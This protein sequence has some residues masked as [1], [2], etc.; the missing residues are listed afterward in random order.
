MTQPFKFL[1]LCFVLVSISRC[2]FCVAR[3]MPLLFS[4]FLYCQLSYVSWVLP[5]CLLLLACTLWLREKANVNP[6]TNRWKAS[7]VTFLVIHNSSCIMTIIIFILA[8][9]ISTYGSCIN[10]S[11]CLEFCVTDCI[12]FLS[13][14]L[15]FLTFSFLKKT[16]SVVWLHFISL[17]HTAMSCDF[18]EKNN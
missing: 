16:S 2:N 6:K 1:I 18:G 11:L 5:S 14:L 10:N 8:F 4:S 17:P 9:C 3:L 12:K 13:Y 15:I 7:L